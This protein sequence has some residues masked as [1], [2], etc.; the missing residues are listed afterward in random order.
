[1]LFSKHIDIFRY[2]KCPSTHH[3][4]RLPSRQE[5]C[6]MV[7]N[8][9]PE[10]AVLLNSIQIFGFTVSVVTFF[11]TFLLP[12][13]SPLVCLLSQ[14]SGVSFTHYCDLSCGHFPFLHG[15]VSLPCSYESP[16]TAKRKTIL[17]HR[18]MTS[19]HVRPLFTSPRTSPSCE[20][21]FVSSA[22]NDISNCT[23]RPATNSRCTSK[24][25]RLP[26][27]S[28]WSNSEVDIQRC[29]LC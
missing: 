21:L 14:L 7:V 8:N 24:T 26:P 28:S 9:I 5:L 13:L 10:S 27:V 15:I 25:N 1:M 29:C 19:H 16:F 20:N 23:S 22:S 17:L 11:H 12:T 2:T 18:L 3:Y 4:T 6:W